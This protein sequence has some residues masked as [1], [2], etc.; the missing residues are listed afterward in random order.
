MH[1]R[2]TQM[3]SATRTGLCVA[4]G[5]L[6]AACSATTPPA[7]EASADAP[8]ADAAP[9][10]PA[11]A[12]A[13]VEPA[14]TPAPDAGAPAF[15]GKVWRVVES[16]GV[17]EGTRY[18]FLTDGTLVIEAPAGNPPGYGKWTY[19]DGKLSIEEEGMTYPTDVVHVD[20]SRLEL[21]SHN[22]GGTLDIKLEHAPDAPLPSAP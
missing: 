12:P 1:M 8:A 15:V 7:A 18:A 6:L 3:R 11:P 9:V 16:S 10:E 19:T 5:A 2:N 22:P 4:L 13:P 20:A 21:R 17:A 14:P